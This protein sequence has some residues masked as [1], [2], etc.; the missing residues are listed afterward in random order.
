MEIDTLYSNK[1]LIIGNIEGIPLKVLYTL[2]FMHDS[3]NF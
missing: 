2:V 3:N 1:S